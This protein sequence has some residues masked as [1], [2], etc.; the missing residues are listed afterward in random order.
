MEKEAVVLDA[1]VWAQLT[2]TARTA[3]I[4]ASIVKGHIS[5]YCTTVTKRLVSD[6]VKETCPPFGRGKHI[7]EATVAEVDR[8]AKIHLDRQAKRKEWEDYCESQRRLDTRLNK[9]YASRFGRPPFHPYRR[10]E[11]PYNYDEEREWDRLEELRDKGDRCVAI[12]IY[13]DHTVA[14]ITDVFGAHGE[15]YIAVVP[16]T[17]GTPV[18]TAIR[19]RASN[20]VE[21]AIELGGPKVASAFIRGISVTTD[22]VGRRSTIHYPDGDLELPWRSVRFNVTKNEWNHDVVEHTRTLI[23]GITEVDEPDNQTA[24]DEE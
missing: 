2:E 4:A 12:T 10:R 1:L 8:Q 20:F 9:A 15:A 5:R 17:G 7:I 21:A 19:S 18:Y 16:R 24:G 6:R 13:C 11:G 23:R 3:R 22:W 14:L